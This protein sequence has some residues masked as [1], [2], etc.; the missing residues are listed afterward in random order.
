MSLERS[1]R[2]IEMLVASIGFRFGIATHN[3]SVTI[4]SSPTSTMNTNETIRHL[5]A[6][7][8]SGIAGAV[9]E[10]ST[11]VAFCV[12]VAIELSGSAVVVVVV[13]LVVIV[14]VIGGQLGGV[15]L[16]VVAN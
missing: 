4:N 7:L 1:G 5:R 16:Q 15:R 2:G 12:L 11:D 13:G 10:I 6:S 3:K 8:S 14:F 9:G